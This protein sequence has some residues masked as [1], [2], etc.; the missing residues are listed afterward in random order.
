MDKFELVKRAEDCIVF[1]SSDDL[2]MAY[3]LLKN[4]N[5]ILVSWKEKG[6]V[7]SEIL[8]TGIIADVI[9][10]KIELKAEQVKK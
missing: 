7:V 8:Q 6:K 10:K 2:E 3:E 4:G 5:E 9:D 1:E